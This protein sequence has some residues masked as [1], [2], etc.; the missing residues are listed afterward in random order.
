MMH[1]MKVG[2][3]SFLEVKDVC[4]EC[5]VRVWKNSCLENLCVTDETSR[6]RIH[7]CYHYQRI[8]ATLNTTQFNLPR[9]N[10]NRANYKHRRYPRCD[11]SH[12]WTG[13]RCHF[14][15]DD[16]ILPFYRG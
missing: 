5:N 16:C 8:S 3:W 2:H 4:A 10:A 12:K 11:A 14:G 7:H 13:W 15:S 1:V 9:R 6:G